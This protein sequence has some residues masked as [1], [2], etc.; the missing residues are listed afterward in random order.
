VTNSMYYRDICQ[1][2]LRKTTKNLS[3]DSWSPDRDINLGLPKHEAVVPTNQPR[4]SVSSSSF[5]G[6][7]LWPLPL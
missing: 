3:Q 7:V 5:S 2:G 1:T 4:R 6:F